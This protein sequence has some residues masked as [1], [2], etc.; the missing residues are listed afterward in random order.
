MQIEADVSKDGVL[1]AILPA[2]YRGKRVHVIIDDEAEHATA[3]WAAISAVLDRAESTSIASRDHRE[4]LE[5]IR[6]FRES[7]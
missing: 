7:S 1:T 2:R 3:Q 4:I 5:E 6:Q